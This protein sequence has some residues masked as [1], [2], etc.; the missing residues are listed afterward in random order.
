MVRDSK[1][2]SG[3]KRQAPREEKPSETLE[4]IILSLEKAAAGKRI[5]ASDAGP[6]RRLRALLSPEGRPSGDKEG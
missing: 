2:T 6:L 4:R 5:S 3:A 1:K